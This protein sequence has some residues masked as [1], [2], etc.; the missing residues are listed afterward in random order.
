MA[1]FP[2]GVGVEHGTHA[3]LTGSRIVANN[4]VLSSRPSDS[5]QVVYSN[6]LV[7]FELFQ[8]KDFQQAL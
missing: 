8:A 2:L 3:I 7:A 5:L 6:T 4:Y 1:Y